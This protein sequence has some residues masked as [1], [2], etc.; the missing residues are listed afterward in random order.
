MNSKFDSLKLFTKYFKLTYKI[1]IYSFFSTCLLGL[2]FNY[3]LITRNSLLAV[4]SGY[5][6]AVLGS[7]S[8]SMIITNFFEKIWIIASHYWRVTWEPNPPPELLRVASKMDYK[9]PIKFGIRYDIDTAYAYNNSVVIGVVPLLLLDADE[10][11]SIFSHEIAHIQGRH[12]LKSTLMLYL[13]MTIIVLGLLALPEIMRYISILSAATISMIPISW[14]FELQAD[15]KASI[16]TGKENTI[17]ALVKIAIGKDKNE[18]SLT[19]P[20]IKDRIEYIRGL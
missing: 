20:S 7:F 1:R 14:Y 9:K 11:E 3:G 13:P 5:P 2:L 18:P 8:A 16:I 17:S 10:V 19:H 6:F 4:I 15:K 12:S